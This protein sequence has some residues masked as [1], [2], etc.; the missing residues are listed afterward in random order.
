MTN[1]AQQRFDA[2]I[3]AAV[4]QSEGY[5]AKALQEKAARRNAPA[6]GD[7]P[8]PSGVVRASVAASKCKSRGRLY[9][10]QQTGATIFDPAA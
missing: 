10:C 8:Q 5:I 3:R 6:E 2:S 7:K 1:K 9:L 4:T